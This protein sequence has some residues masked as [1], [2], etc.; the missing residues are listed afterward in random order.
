VRHLADA[1]TVVGL[2][3]LWLMPAD[4]SGSQMAAAFGLIGLCVGTAQQIR[5]PTT[6]GSRRVFAALFAL[7]CLGALVVGGDIMTM[8]MTLLGGWTVGLGFAA[9]FDPNDSA[10]VERSFSGQVIR[11]G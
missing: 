8:A 3:A 2:C 9:S 10:P 11:R 1:G 7:M 5:R 6:P 4:L